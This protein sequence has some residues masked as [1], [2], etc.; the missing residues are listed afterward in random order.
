MRDKF[1]LVKRIYEIGTKVIIWH[2]QKL[3]S[4]I[5]NQR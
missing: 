5:E 2:N 4:I 1:K 3:I